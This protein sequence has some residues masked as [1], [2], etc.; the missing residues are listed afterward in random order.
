MQEHIKL[1]QISSLEKVFL[2]NNG[3]WTEQKEISLLKGDRASYQIAYC[4]DGEYPGTHLT[5]RVGI[6]YSVKSPIKDMLDIRMVG[7]VPVEFASFGN[8]DD[9][10][11]TLEPG[12]YPDPLFKAVRRVYATIA[13]WHSLFI[14]IK[15]D[16]DVKAGTYPVDITFKI[17][18]PNWADFIDIKFENN[19]DSITLHM[20]VKVIDAVLPKQELIY[21][22]WFH[23][24]CISEFYGCKSFSEKHWKMLDKFI[25][26][27]AENGINSILTPIFTPPLDTHVNTTRPTA[28]LIDI[29]VQNGEYTFG[30]DKFDRWVDMCRKNGI[31]NFEMAHLF[32][33]W[34]AKACPKIMAKVDGRNKQIFGWKTASDSP[35][36]KEFLSKFLPALVNRLK[37]NGIDKNT[38]FHISDEPGAEHLENYK[39][40]RDF[41]KPYLKDFIITDAMSNYEF[42]ESGAVEHPIVATNHIE[43][44]IKNKVDGLFGY[45]CSGQYEDVSNRFLCMPSSRNRSICLPM[46]K[47]N[48]VGFLHWG[49]NFYY[50]K[51]SEY[52]IN[53]FLNTDAYYAFPAGDSFSVYPGREGPIESIILTVFAEALCDLR[54]MR[55]LESYIGH[56]AVVKLIEDMAGTK[57]SFSNYPHEADFYV[58]LRRRINEEIEKHIKA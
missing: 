4:K 50:S 22:Q 48:L 5:R 41:V 26:T 20:S 6:S 36:Y 42:Y 49:Y 27:A 21:T 30:F 11:H 16:K 35:E 45:Y 54:A 23:A 29:T 38:L 17:D 25:K 3:D 28:Q 8:H 9:Y 46:F 18:D 19:K 1:K 47:Y 51:G 57:I 58:E 33:Q 53:P 31:E 55:L 14:M 32:T 15:T 12:L 52:H 13:T 43:P 10:V 2:K 37:K 40:L 44:F 34:G 7:N 24:D 56:D 39:K